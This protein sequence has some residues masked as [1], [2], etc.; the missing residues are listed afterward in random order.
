[1]LNQANYPSGLTKHRT[2]CDPATT[3]ATAPTTSGNASLTSQPIREVYVCLGG[4][5][6]ISLSLWEAQ[7]TKGHSLPPVSPIKHT[8]SVSVT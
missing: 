8:H 7:A 3:M 4:S 5:D 1:M 6:G 2:G